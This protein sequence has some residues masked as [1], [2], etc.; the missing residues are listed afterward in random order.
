MLAHSEKY[1][2]DGFAGLARSWFWLG[3]CTNFWLLVVFFD[4]LAGLVECLAELGHGLTLGKLLFGILAEGFLL[5]F[6]KLF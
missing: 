3:E 2:C 6:G 5:R 4:V 1:V